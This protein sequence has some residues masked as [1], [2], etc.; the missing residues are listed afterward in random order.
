MENKKRIINLEYFREM[1]HICP[2]LPDEGAGIIPG[3][4][5]VL[6]DE[7]DEEI[8]WKS[9]DEDDDEVDER[10]DDQD[11]DD[12][13]QDDDD[14]DDYDQDVNDDDQDTDN[15]DDDFVHTKLSIHEEEAKDEESFILIIQTQENS[16]D[17]ASLGLNVGGEEGHDAEDDN[18]EFY[19]DVNIN[20]KGRDVQMIDV[21][22]IQEFKDTHVTL[23]PVNPNGQQQSS[24]VSSQFVTTPTP[25]TTAPRTF[26]QDLPNFGSLFGF[27]HRLKTLEANFLEFVQTNQFTGAVS[28]IL[29]IVERY[30]DQ[31]MNEA[32]KVTIQIQYDRLRDEAQTKNEEFLNNLD[33]NIQKI[34]KVQVKEEVKLQ[35]S[36]ILPKTKKTVNEQL[37]AKV[38]TRS[39]NS[40]NTSYAM[41]ADLSEMELKNILIKKMESNKSIYR[42]DEQRNLY[43]ALKQKKPPTP[44]TAWN[45]TLPA[46][47]RSIQPW[48]SDLAKQADSRSSFNELMDTPVDFS[49]YLMNRL[50][51]DTLTPKLLAGPTYELIKGSCKSLQYP[52][53]LLKPLPLIPNS[54]GRR[55]IPFDHFINN[56]L[57]YLCGGASSRKYITS[58]TKTKAA[59]YGHIKW[60]EDLSTESLLEMSTQNGES[61][62]ELQIVEWHNYKHLDWITVRRDDDK[63]YKFKEGN[64]KRLRIQDIKY[65]L[66]LLVQGKL[67]NLTVEERFAFNVSLRT[68][69]R[70]IN[71][72]MWIDELHKL[73]DGTLN[74][75]RTALDDRL[76]GIRMKYLP[77]A[78]WRKSDKE[79]AATMIHAIDKQLKTRRIM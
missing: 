13:D 6:S 14:Q 74:D 58:V 27:N 22:T 44:Y 16:N 32:V 64:F 60:I 11:D 70:S 9:S 66:L 24:S 62:P 75:V 35:V 53:N 61:S 47:H 23:T 12:D 39:S 54:R 36:K 69:T 25:P 52:H 7:F 42:S 3:V 72:L 2:R 45:K 79:R 21:H 40:S 67:T 37:E 17:D 38:L 10:S 34:I 76:K 15:D 68:F 56:D 5:D 65:M 55:V 51:V 20:L 73:S 50:K 46:T 48:I 8:S 78:I 18:E 59:D 63:I 19:R 4:P 26:L 57:E 41:A 43:K 49:A 71:R 30:M 28:F 31:R 29:G 33:E 77:Q 1:L